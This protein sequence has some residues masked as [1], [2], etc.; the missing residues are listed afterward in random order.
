MVCLYCMAAL[1]KTDLVCLQDGTLTDSI[2]A[3]GDRV[4]QDIGEDAGYVMVTT[5]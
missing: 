5:W 2:S 1:M 3:V 4:A